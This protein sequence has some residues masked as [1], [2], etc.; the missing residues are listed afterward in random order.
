MNTKLQSDVRF[1]KGYCI[2]IT[3]LLAGFVSAFLLTSGIRA[4]QQKTKFGEIDVERI[5]VVEKDGKLKMVISNAE[6]QHPGIIDGRLLDRKRPAGLLFFNDKGDE[7]GGLSFSGNQATD[8][9]GSSSGLLAFDRFN[10]DQTV[11]LQYGESGGRYYSGLRV[12]DRPDQSLG[13]VVDELKKIEKMKDGPEKTAAQA[14][15][16]EMPAARTAERLFV[17]RDRENASV[18]RLNDANGKMR[19]KLSVDASGAPKL[20]FLDENGKVSFSLPQN[21]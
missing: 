21:K 3:L 5:N 2:V 10:Q 16:R 6:R 8:G 20:E 11:G 1:L 4:D 17:G 18:V 15:L 12:W 19:V 7:C 14:A 13:V 9:K